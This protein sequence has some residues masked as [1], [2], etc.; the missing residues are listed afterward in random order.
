MT[1]E[2]ENITD[3]KQAAEGFT[4][5]AIDEF[6]TNKNWTDLGLRYWTLVDEK[7]GGKLITLLTTFLSNSLEMYLQL[8]ICVHNIELLTKK[9]LHFKLEFN[10]AI[11]P[12]NQ[13][14]MAMLGCNCH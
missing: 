2:M 3:F 14:L 4:K 1:F 8:T 10:F 5:M 9:L 11:P 7:L 6:Y 12:K 13:R